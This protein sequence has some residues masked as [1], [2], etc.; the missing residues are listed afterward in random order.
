M[1]NSPNKQRHHNKV[2]FQTPIKTSNKENEPAPVVPSQRPQKYGY[3]QLQK[4]PLQKTGF[5]K[6]LQAVS[7][8]SLPKPKS[9]YDFPSATPIAAGAFAQV[10]HAREQLSSMPAAYREV[11]LKRINVSTN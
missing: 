10:L 5:S 3:H 9:V 7:S 1:N 11:A 8:W 4:Q 6:P 2:R